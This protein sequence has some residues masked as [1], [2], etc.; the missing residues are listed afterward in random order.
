MDASNPGGRQQ[1]A[2][3]RQA[4]EA[5]KGKTARAAIVVPVLPR[6][7]REEDESRSRPR[8]A[9]SP[10]ARFAEAIGLARAIDLDPVYTEIVTVNVPR[11]ATLLGTG[12]I[13]ELAEHIKQ[14]ANDYY[15]KYWKS[16]W[17]RL[18]EKHAVGR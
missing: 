2:K 6:F 16:Y 18:H 9:R 4:D 14:A 10:E 15:D 13:E 5:L 12:K 11:P 17:K 7:P 1:G 3:E 8:L